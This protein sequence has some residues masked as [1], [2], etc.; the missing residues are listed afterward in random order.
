[1]RLVLASASPRRKELLSILGVEFQVF[2]CDVDENIDIQCPHDYV[3]ELAMLKARTAAS[4]LPED[5]LVIAADTIVYKN[6]IL[7]KPID[8]GNAFNMIKFLQGSY[9]EVY[10]G[11]ALYSS[12]GNIYKKGYERTVVKMKEMSH[13]EIEWYLNRNEYK[14]KAGAYG[15]QGTA[16]IFIEYI[17]GCYFNV[18]GL[19]VSKLYSMLKEINAV[20]RLKIGLGGL[21]DDG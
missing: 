11:I 8:R 6:G 3:M 15:I 12:G 9:H 18:V 2:E 1:M 10:T 14:D 13:D 5:V 21:K 20:N 7:G 16:S 17:Q 4:K 19:P